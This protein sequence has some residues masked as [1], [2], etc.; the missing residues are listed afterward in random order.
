MKIMTNDQLQG[1]FRKLTKHSAAFNNMVQDALLTCAYYGY[2]DGN[3]EPF[4]QL[5]GSVGPGVHLQHITRWIELVAG[6]GRVHKERIVLNKKVFEVAGVTN[7][8]TFQEH[9][10]NM[11]PIM[12]HEAGGK[13]RAESVFDEGAYMKRVLKKLSAEGYAGLAA[14]LKQAELAYLVKMAESERDHEEAEQIRIDAEH[15][16]AQKDAQ[17]QANANLAIANQ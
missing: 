8:E 1:M 12:W 17:D 9:Y 7:E 15:D 2:K 16:K 5:I 13:Q 4:N 6:I 10:D 3:T 14:A 11:A